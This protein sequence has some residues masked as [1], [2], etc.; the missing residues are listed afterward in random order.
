M[1]VVT[2]KGKQVVIKEFVYVNPY[3][4]AEFQN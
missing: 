4:Q 2:V 1:K 3:G